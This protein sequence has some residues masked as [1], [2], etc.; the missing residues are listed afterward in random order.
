MVAAS[1]LRYRLN[2]ALHEPPGLDR[3]AIGGP[4][5]GHVLSKPDAYL[6]SVGIVTYEPGEVGIGMDSY[7]TWKVQ[8]SS[9]GRHVGLALDLLISLSPDVVKIVR[10]TGDTLDPASSDH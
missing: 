2:P 3:L 7:R 10:I 4:A 9:M 5:H 6:W 1:L 8:D